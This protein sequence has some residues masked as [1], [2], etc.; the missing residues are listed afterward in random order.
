MEDSELG[1]MW[2]GAVVTLFEVQFRY[3][4]GRAEENHENTSG[5]DI[6]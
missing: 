2:K 3:F 4:P 6:R 1:G 5:Q